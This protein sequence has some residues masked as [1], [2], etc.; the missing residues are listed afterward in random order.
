MGLLCFFE[1]K[2]GHGFLNVVW[3]VLMYNLNSRIEGVGEGCV[4]D[5]GIGRG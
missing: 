4:G 1:W 3:N 5:G 2:K